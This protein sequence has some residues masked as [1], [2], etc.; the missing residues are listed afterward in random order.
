VTA[1][2]LEHGSTKVLKRIAVVTFPQIKLVVENEMQD[3]ELR[4][5]FFLVN[6]W[7]D[8]LLRLFLIHG[9][10]FHWTMAS[11]DFSLSY[12]KSSFALGCKNSDFCCP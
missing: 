4:V 7:E 1:D 12:K 8:I 10:A 9:S 5:N 2:D 11:K 6:L 3:I